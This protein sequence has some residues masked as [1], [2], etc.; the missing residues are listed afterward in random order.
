MVEISG[1]TWAV[2]VGVVVALYALD[3]V[4]AMLRPHRVGPPEARAWSAFYIAVA[5]A[6][7]A[8]L[9]IAH[10]FL[11]GIEYL[12]GYIVEKGLS[13]DNVFVFL[14]IMATFAAP[15][16]HQHTVLTLGIMLALFMRAIFI[17]LGAALISLF[18][19]AFLIFGLLLI[20]TPSDP[21]CATARS[22]RQTIT[23]PGTSAW[24]VAAQINLR[25]GH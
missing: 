3:L 13:T 18:S 19:F 24:R 2:T 15:E 23:W 20:Y 25:Q 10:G 21:S 5:V 16:E 14:I 4:L 9:F 11:Y 12:V 8:W 7:G 17:A 1:L 6:F 22:S